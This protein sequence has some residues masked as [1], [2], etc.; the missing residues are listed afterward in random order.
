MLIKET[1]FVQSEYNECFTQDEFFP[2]FYK[3]TYFI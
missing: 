2:L 3:A 1:F